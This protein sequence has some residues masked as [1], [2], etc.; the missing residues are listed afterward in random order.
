MI[1]FSS[2]KLINHWMEM[3]HLIRQSRISL[4]LLL[5]LE[6]IL[7]EASG[8]ALESPDTEDVGE[9]VILSVEDA[10]DGSVTELETDSEHK[11][12]QSCRDIT[13]QKTVSLTVRVLYTL[14]T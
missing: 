6:D 3:L 11:V 4:H 5:P 12:R 14:I 2:G 8:L 7:D 13:L 1:A 10:V 9:R